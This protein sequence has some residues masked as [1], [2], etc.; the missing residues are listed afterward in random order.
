MSR[1][2]R[3]TASPPTGDPTDDLVALVLAARKGEEA[4]WNALVDQFSGLVWSVCGSFR[5]DRAD[6]ADVFQLVWL[7]LLEHLS[8][9]RE[10]SRLPGWLSTTCRNE[11][12]ALLKRRNRCQPTADEMVFDR[13]YDQATG[14][15]EPTLLADRDAVLW[16]AFG[17]LRRRCR[18]V[19][20]V[21]VVEPE[22]APSYRLAAQALGI[23]IG[24]LGPTRARCLD[25]LRKLL[26]TKG[27]YGAAR[28]S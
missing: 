6:A 5:L 9:L 24:S 27:I 7:R 16:E 10:P 2:N 25:E 8:T 22:S 13:G 21:L 19:L 26:D 11:C 14:A 18:E 1:E 12:H 28:D 17:R 20:R 23:P 3:G 4:A 15:D